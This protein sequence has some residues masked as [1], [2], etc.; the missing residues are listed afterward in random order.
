MKIDQFM[1]DF[2]TGTNQK[3]PPIKIADCVFALYLL[4]SCF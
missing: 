1:S 4:Y 3:A 2:L